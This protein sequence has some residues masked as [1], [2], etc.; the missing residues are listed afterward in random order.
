MVRNVSRKI[1]DSVAPMR[2]LLT[3]LMI[4]SSLFAQGGPRPNLEGA[5]LGTLEAGPGVKLRIAFHITKSSQG[6]LTGTFDSLDQ[7]AL[8]LPLSSV[9]FTG[10]A[11]T[12]ESQAPPA[13]YSG[14]LNAEGTEITGQWHQGGADLALNL[15]KVDSIPVTE[16]PQEPRPPFPYHTEDVTYPSKAAAVQ[17]AGTLTL[18]QTGGPFPAVLL[19]TGS[20][21]QDRDETLLGHKPFLLIA[22]YL[23]RHGIAVL[24]VDDRG[25]AKST[26]NF[27]ASTTADFV[28][29]AAGSLAYLKS[30]KN[31]D[32]KHIGLI[33][34]SEGAVVAPMLA[35]KSD[36]VA[37]IVMMAGTGVPGSEVLK[38]QGSAIMRSAGASDSAVAANVEAQEQ[39]FTLSDP[40]LSPAQI[41]ARKQELEKSLIAKLPEDQRQ[42]GEPFVRRQIE[43]AASPWMRYFIRLDPASRSPRVEASGTGAERR[44]SISRCFPRRTFR[45]S[46]RHSKRGRTPT[47]KS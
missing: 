15:K 40:N 28:D 17:L 43:G 16:H 12:I 34:H 18:P 10:L 35:V 3:L 37:F 44:L 25:T 42:K 21:A 29:D 46:C 47:I 41:A 22:D 11:I 45:P 7:G 30:H 26:G 23:T 8:G 14:T 39:L 32:S 20:G 24:R 27:D 9:K 33:G 4:A 31:I 36:D 13:G 19:I 2:T 1:L 38:A 6:E 5:W